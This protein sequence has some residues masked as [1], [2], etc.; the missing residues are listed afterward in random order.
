MRQ[1]TTLADEAAAR[2]LAAWLVTQK[3]EA[4]AEPDQ[5]GWAIWV[6]DEDRLPAA[7]AQLAS[8]LEAP[9]DPKYRGAEQQ[10]SAV[11][12]AEREKRE[13]A[14][15]NMRDMSRQWG[16]GGVATPRSSPVVM[17]LIIVSVIVAVLTSFGAARNSKLLAALQICDGRVAYFQ[18]P[19]NAPLEARF[20]P[21]WKNIQQGEVWRLV[22][23]AFIHF[24]IMHIV[25]NLMVLY[26]FGGQIEHRIKSLKFVVLVIAVAALSNVAETLYGSFWRG[27]YF[28]LAGNFG[29]MSGVVYGLFGFLYVRSQIFRDSGY[30]LR[31]ETTLMVMVWLFGCIVWN[32]L[33][34]GWRP[35]GSA[36]IANAAHVVGLLTG[37]VLAYLPIFKS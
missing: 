4:T 15:R 18:S 8:F 17:L 21:V 20:T 28:P 33:P 9:N 25:F 1:L 7:K 24:G 11:L 29:G 3:I 6:R 14:Q 34:A 10:A 36:M 23:P 22:T 31:R 12:R 26:D 32:M 2:R 37:G 19:P 16:R 30:M 27:P 5:N 35:G 13:R